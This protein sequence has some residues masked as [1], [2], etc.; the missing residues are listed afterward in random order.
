MSVPLIILLLSVA[1]TKGQNDCV[2]PVPADKV[3]IDCSDRG[4][5]T[6]PALPPKAVEV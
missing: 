3:Y 1:L 5:T 6:V 2:G 4:I